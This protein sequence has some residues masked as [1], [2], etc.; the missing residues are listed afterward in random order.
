MQTQTMLNDRFSISRRKMIHLSLAM[1]GGAMAGSSLSILGAEKELM[2]TPENVLGPFYPMTKPLE[3]D[4]DL[5]MIHGHKERAQGQI[6]HLSGRVLNIKGE[7]MKGATLELWQANT[8]GRYSH[9]MDENK[10]PLDPNFQG[11]AVQ[12]TDKEGRYRFKTIKPGSYPI[13]PNEARP[14]HIH[15]EIRSQKSRLITQM[16]FPGEPLN[17]KDSLFT[18]LEEYAPAAVCSI[19]EPGPDMEPDALALNWDVVLWERV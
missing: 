8:H 6:I 18:M 19:H 9:P 5:T 3:Q 1:A 11:Y 2:D 14:P 10:A 4:A 17:E 15:F 13:G 7:P 16:F 12:E